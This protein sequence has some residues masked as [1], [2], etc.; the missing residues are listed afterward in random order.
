M[1][2]FLLAS[3][4]C[5]NFLVPEQKEHQKGSIPLRVILGQW[6]YITEDWQ[7]RRGGISESEQQ[8]WNWGNVELLSLL[9]ITQ[10]EDC[11]PLTYS[12]RDCL[13]LEVWRW[14]YTWLDYTPK[15]A[16]CWRKGDRV[17]TQ[18]GWGY[19][20]NSLKNRCGRCIKMPTKGDFVSLALITLS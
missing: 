10:L 4:L 20:K 14:V 6:K 2:T 9:K 13:I 1:I 3:L 12:S 15:D 7:V 11:C 5:N 16:Q 19:R 18:Q 17:H 8:T